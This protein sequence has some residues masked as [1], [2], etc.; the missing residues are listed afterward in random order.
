MDEVVTKVPYVMT[1]EYLQWVIDTYK[2]DYVVHG[3]KQRA[4]A[5]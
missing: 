1:A 5:L 4:D 2:V 3:G